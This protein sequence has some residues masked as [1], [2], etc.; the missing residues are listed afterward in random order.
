MAAS[1][2]E[3]INGCINSENKVTQVPISLLMEN[4]ILIQA[5]TT[6]LIPM[7]LSNSSSVMRDLAITIKSQDNEE[8][9]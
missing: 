2:I 8:I 3:A 6:L 7:G 9:I 1:A 4:L 5:S